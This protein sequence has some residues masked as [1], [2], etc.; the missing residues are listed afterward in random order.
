M[1][2]P[3]N[4]GAAVFTIAVTDNDLGN[5][6]IEFGGAEYQVEIA[7]RIEIAEIMTVTGNLLIIFFAHP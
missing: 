4:L 7:K 1:A 5:F 2:E 3:V 6:Q